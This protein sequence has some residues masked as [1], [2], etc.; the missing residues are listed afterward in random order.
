VAFPLVDDPKTMLL[1][2]TTTPWTLPSNLG[3][4]VHPDFDYVKIHDPTRGDANLIIHADLLHCIY[5]AKE[6]KKPT[7]KIV[8]KYKGSDMK[9]WRYVPLFDYFTEQYED[10]AYKV[11]LDKYVTKDSGSGIVHQAPAF[12]EDDHRIALLNGII[13]N[14]EMPPCPIDEVGTFTKEIP[15]FAGQYIKVRG[16]WM[17]LLHNLTR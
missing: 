6:L 4:C 8:T 13:R 12:G 16:I 14:D 1:A 11:V 9:G 10:R 3:L 5:S 15:D 7:Y 2:W 17:T